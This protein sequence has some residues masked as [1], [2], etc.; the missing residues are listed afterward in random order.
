MSKVSDFIKRAQAYT[1]FWVAVAGGILIIVTGNLELPAEIIKW[2]Q[3]GISIATAFSVF[4][5]PNVT[6]DE[7]GAHE[8]S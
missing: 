3:T 7:P 1:K 6:A 8:A 5:F 2:I 4:Q